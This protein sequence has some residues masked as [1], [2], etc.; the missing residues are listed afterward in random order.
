MFETIKSYET[1]GS[2]TV[3]AGETVLSVKRQSFDAG[4][5]LMDAVEGQHYTY[6][7]E[8]NDG[9]TVYKYN[10]MAPL[11]ITT[12]KHSF[13]THY[14][15]FVNIN[16]ETLKGVVLVGGTSDAVKGEDYTLSDNGV[17]TAITDELT[18][19]TKKLP[20]GKINSQT[21][22]KDA[23]GNSIDGWSKPVSLFGAK[24]GMYCKIA[25]D[26]KGGVH[27]AAYDSNSGSLWYAYLSNYTEPDKA[28]ICRVDTGMV[29]HNLDLDVALDSTGEKA[30][31]CISYYAL[32][33]NMPKFARLANAGT[34]GDGIE[35]GKYTGIWD[36][37]YVP[38]DSPLVRDNTSVGLWKG[39][40][41][42]A[43]DAG[44]IKD[45]TT[46]QSQ[47][48]DSGKCYGNGSK[49]AVLG[50]KNIDKSDVTKGYFETAQLTGTPEEAY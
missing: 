31:P 14:P 45:S 13:L 9:Y 28:K 30:L 47:N 46:G 6:S 39:A 7:V 11:E 36:V 17:Y 23:D 41:S 33:E 2:F 25:F 26:A 44:V 12:K 16:G 27:I 8:P 18:I 19:N 21:G 3:P 50:Y 22:K 4:Y 29:G 37:S 35:N 10:A 42:A 38:T 20:A 48:G 43:T 1:S 5:D 49:N 40:L 34:F 24:V 32:G 15:Q